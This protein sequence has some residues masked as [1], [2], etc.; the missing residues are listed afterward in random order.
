MNRAP[1]TIKNTCKT[2]VERGLTMK[3][4]TKNVMID[5]L[6]LKGVQVNKKLKVAEV[7]S[8]YASKAKVLAMGNRTGSYF[9]GTKVNTWAGQ[10]ARGIAL[11]HINSTRDIRRLVTKKYG[12]KQTLLRLEDEGL[13]RFADKKKTVFYLTT[14]GHEVASMYKSRLIK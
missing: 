14:T 2:H 4:L 9:F 1:H 13:I 3:K 6:A 10:V 5:N 11:G 7:A 12:F 8:V